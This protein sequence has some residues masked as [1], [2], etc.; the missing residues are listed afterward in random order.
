M[1]SNDMDK[2]YSRR[3]F[4]KL[5]A[6]AGLGAVAG[7]AIVS[8]CSR[9]LNYPA[10]LIVAGP[11]DPVRIGFV[12]VGLQGSSHVRNFLRIDGV[13]VKAV[14]DIV[15]EKVARIQ[16]WVVEAGQP[17]PEGYSRGDT[18]FLRLCEQEDLD[19]VFTA[20]PWKWHVPVCV[21][22]MENGKHAATEVPAAVTLDECWQMVETSEKTGKYCVMME[23][24]NYNRREMMF[25]N[26]VRKGMFGELV[27]SECGY[28]HD[29]RAIKFENRNEGL[30]RR[31]H[32]VTRNGNIYPTHGLGPTA[33]WMDI[34]RGDQF[35]YLVS[36]SS[37]SKGLQLYTQE[38]FEPDDPR[39][40]ESYALGDVNVTLIRTKEG[41]T[42]TLYHDCNLP[43]PY[44]RI[45]L[46]QGTRG[47]AQGYP[48]RIYIEGRSPSHQWEPLEDYREEFEHPLWSSQGERARGAGHGGM[49]YIEDY[50]L[51]QALRTGTEP[52]MDVYDAAAI[53]AVCELSERSV[54]NRGRSMDFPDFTR[55]MWKTRPPLGIVQA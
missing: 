19:L 14:C 15:E 18:D 1:E 32:S 44:S 46:I 26:M 5:G 25:L 50:R 41:R 47:I 51:I 20:T 34:N 45:N 2:S 29:L 6:A 13:E 33:Q 35:D 21:A 7:A 54:A 48:D 55:G 17:K 12:G 31:A 27:H 53:S 16:E 9:E 3:E 8:G 4:V 23:N 28:L 43:R 42:I 39:R 36:V 30:W 52:D 37:V 38:H 40:N 49:D 11:V 24:C 22:A 10:D